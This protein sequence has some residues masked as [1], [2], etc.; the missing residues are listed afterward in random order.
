MSALEEL[1]DIKNL[2]NQGYILEEIHSN[3]TDRKI[4][5]KCTT[6]SDILYIHPFTCNCVIKN[7]KDIQKLLNQEG[8]ILEE[9][10]LISTKPMFEFQFKI[11][12]N[13]DELDKSKNKLNFLQWFTSNL[14]Y[15][16]LDI[17]YLLSNM[18]LINSIVTESDISNKF[19][20]VFYINT[21]IS[22]KDEVLK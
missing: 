21:L 2:L 22:L 7:N 3:I 5:Q 17:N 16:L 20:N 14:K 12:F 1:K 15:K 18:I 13:N 8:Y 6:D 10:E 4:I 11:Y 9:K 19:K